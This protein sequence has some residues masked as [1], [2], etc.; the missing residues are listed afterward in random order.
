MTQIFP[1]IDLSR[2]TE[3]PVQ[4][5][6]RP[7]PPGDPL[8]VMAGLNASL[9]A[10]L[11]NFSP[12]DVGVCQID[13]RLQLSLPIPNWAEWAWLESGTSTSILAGATTTTPVYTV[14]LDERATLHSLYMVRASGDNLVDLFTLTI[15][16]A[17]RGGGGSAELRLLNLTT[18]VASAFWPHEGSQTVDNYVKPP[19]LLEPGTVINIAP[20]GTG[21][22][23][24]TF[25]YWIYMTR[26]KI[27]RALAP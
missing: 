22:A 20:D 3:S 9:I 27:I 23:A 2:F 25:N 26:T 24:S 17:Y 12:G 18:P 7:F 19:V 8:G 15:P 6:A 4:N 11:R 5:G 1:D 10:L 21:V 13:D 16:D 14:P